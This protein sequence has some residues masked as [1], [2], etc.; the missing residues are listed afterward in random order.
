MTDLDRAIRA[1]GNKECPDCATPLTLVR[2]PCP[3]E[4]SRCAV[5]HK[6][7]ICI[8]CSERRREEHDRPATIG[9]LA[10]LGAK[11]DRLIETIAERLG[12]PHD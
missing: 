9:E 5:L 12:V 11:V 3:S 10:A 4:H 6:K 8:P 2:V 7:S 1:R